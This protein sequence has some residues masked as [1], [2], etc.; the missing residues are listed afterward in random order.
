M[1]PVTVRLDAAIYYESEHTYL[2]R[3]SIPWVIHPRYPDRYGS[4]LS[5]YVYLDT[6][7]WEIRTRN[8]E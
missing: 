3:I 4:L 7:A 8:Y 1:G 6:L 5:Y 2:S